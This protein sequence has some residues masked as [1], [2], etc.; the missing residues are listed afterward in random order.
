VTKPEAAKTV[1]TPELFDC[2]CFED[3]LLR[4]F[5]GLILVENNYWFSFREDK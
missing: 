3:A 5:F 4:T 1:T 2:F